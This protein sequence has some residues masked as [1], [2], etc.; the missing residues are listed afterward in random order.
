MSGGIAFVYDDD[1]QFKSRCNLG[2]VD[3]KPLHEE[4]IPELREM[5][6]KHFKY[7][8]SPVAKGILDYWRASIKKFVRVM[9]RDF[10]RVMKESQHQEEDK[11]LHVPE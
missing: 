11:M 8:G 5:L 6:E 2:M 3:L 9:P 1:G 10:A 7:T 4:S